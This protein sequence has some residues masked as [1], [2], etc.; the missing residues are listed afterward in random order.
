MAKTFK[1]VTEYVTKLVNKANTGEKFVLI[2]N[3]FGTKYAGEDIK[4]KVM[5]KFKLKSFP[6]FKSEG[7]PILK[8]LHT[9]PEKIDIVLR[10]MLK[11]DAPLKQVWVD[12]VV[13]RTGISRDGIGDKQYSFS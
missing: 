1:E 7:Y 10:N 9:R 13:K 12:E 11:E 3:V 8:Q 6:N 5:D 2:E 4:S